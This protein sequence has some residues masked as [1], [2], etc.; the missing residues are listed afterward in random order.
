M[1]KTFICLRKINLI[2]NLIFR[3]HIWTCRP[4]TW[5]LMFLAIKTEN[6]TS[7]GTQNKMFKFSFGF[8]CA[9]DFNYIPRLNF[10]YII[11]EVAYFQSRFIFLN[12]RIFMRCTSDLFLP[13]SKPSQENLFCPSR[14][15][16]RLTIKYKRSR[17]R[18]TFYAHIFGIIHEEDIFWTYSIFLNFLT[19]VL[20]Q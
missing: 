18:K 15:T 4:L 10:M 17:I 12:F 3:G 8:L 20:S 19:S 6:K 7:F 14:F 5:A 16:D 11:Q 1:N 13:V 2:L 9:A